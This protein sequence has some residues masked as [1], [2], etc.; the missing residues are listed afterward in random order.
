MTVARA[1]IDR[2]S[3]LYA[4]SLMAEVVCMTKKDLNPGDKID[5][6]GGY[7]VRGYADVA[8]DAKRDNLVPIG[9]VQGATVVKA[10]KAG[11]LLTYDHVELN[12]DS[13]I[14]KLRHQQDAMGLTY[15]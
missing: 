11:E 13:L 10:I 4:E 7:T 3:S 8:K 15:A 6:I 5:G 12:E 2:E 14:V 9:L 1:V